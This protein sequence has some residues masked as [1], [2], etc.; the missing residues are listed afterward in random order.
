MKPQHSLILEA[1]TPLGVAAPH[2][3]K[4]DDSV[5]RSLATVCEAHQKC[6]GHHIDS[7]ERDRKTELHS[8]PFAIK[9][10]V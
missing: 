1:P 3:R 2:R 5:E 4:N 9:G 10:Q 8:S 7:R 6:V